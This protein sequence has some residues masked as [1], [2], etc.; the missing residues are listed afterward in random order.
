MQVLRQQAKKLLKE[1]DKDN[2]GTISKGE[3]PAMLRSM[4]AL[5][6][7]ALHHPPL[8]PAAPCALG[9]TGG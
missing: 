5:R 8:L 1:A 7:P 2:S 9:S 3:M 4:G 6:L